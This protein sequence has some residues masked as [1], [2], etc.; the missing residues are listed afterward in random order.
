MKKILLLML[1]ATTMAD[2]VTN[3][4]EVPEINLRATTELSFNITTNHKYTLYVCQDL[5]YSN[6]YAHPGCKDYRPTKN[7]IYKMWRPANEKWAFFYLEVDGAPGPI[8]PNYVVVT[9]I[10]ST[11]TNLPPTP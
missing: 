4:V 3:I 5:V 11:T 7:R 2:P 9:N 8:T 10:V 6:W 1:T